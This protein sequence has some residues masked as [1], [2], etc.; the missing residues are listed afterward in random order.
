M[1]FTTAMPVLSLVLLSF[2]SYVASEIAVNRAPED[3]EAL[4]SFLLS[5]RPVLTPRT[6][7]RLSNPQMFNLF[8][9]TDESKRRRDDLILRQAPAGSRKLTFR[10]PSQ[11]VQKPSKLLGFQFRQGPLQNIYVDKI[12]PG[13]EAEN[14]MKK[15]QL[16]IGDEVVMVSATFGDEMWSCR[17][18]GIGR[19]ESSMKVRQGALIEF[20]FEGKGKNQKRVQDA[21]DAKEV[22]EARIARLQAE[23]RG[24]EK[25]KREAREARQAAEPEKK[26]FFDGLFR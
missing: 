18:V 13:S 12:L 20:V 7:H 1:I 22:R 10:K 25:Q 16:D 14:Y 3:S 17:G 19:L 6:K 23:I 15:G 8:G 9:D 4:A 24:Q 21:V 2:P 11:T 5:M 26:G